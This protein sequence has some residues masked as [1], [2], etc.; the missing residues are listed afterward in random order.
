MTVRWKCYLWDEPRPAEPREVEFLERRWGIQLPEDYRRLIVVHQGMV[1]EPCVF[2]VGQG[3]DVMGPLLTLKVEPDR[4]YYSAIQAHTLLAPLVPPGIYPFATTPGG[5]Y[6]CFDY[7]Q[8]P[9]SP[10]IVLVTEEASIHP[11][12]NSLREFLDGLHEG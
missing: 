5:E 2:N 1:P 11:L 7:R 9:A 4:E 3:R 6:L 8:P 10:R 12:A